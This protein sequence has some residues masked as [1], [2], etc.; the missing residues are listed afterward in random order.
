MGTSVFAHILL[1]NTAMPHSLYNK[2]A[3]SVTLCKF[4]RIINTQSAV[5]VESSPLR[6]HALPYFIAI[7]R[8]LLVLLPHQI[9]ANVI[10]ER[11]F[12][13]SLHAYLVTHVTTFR[14][15]TSPVLVS[16][17]HC[18]GGTDCLYTGLNIEPTACPPN[19]WRT[20]TGLHGVISRLLQCGLSRS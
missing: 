15:V 16:T 12:S 2:S 11:T 18:F 10:P 19:L 7:R 9:D 13:I 8:L 17:C 6:H 3:I 4:R 14:G 20:I 1:N 5:N